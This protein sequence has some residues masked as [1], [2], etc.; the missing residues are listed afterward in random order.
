MSTL[1]VDM[2]GLT[3]ASRNLAFLSIVAF[4]LLGLVLTLAL[5]SASPD[6]LAALTLY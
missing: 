2:R 4:S 5:L 3:S 1:P 6:T